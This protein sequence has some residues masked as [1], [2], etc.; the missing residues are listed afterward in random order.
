MKYSVNI[1]RVVQAGL[2]GHLIIEHLKK[3]SPLKII[4]V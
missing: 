4:H 1:H 2:I 3:T